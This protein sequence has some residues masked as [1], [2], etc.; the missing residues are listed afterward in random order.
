MHLLA[1]PRSRG[2]RTYGRGAALRLALAAAIATIAIPVGDA[3][4]YVEMP[5]YS[6]SPSNGAHL[7]LTP[8]Q[9]STPV[10][11]ES[12][13]DQYF[14]MIAGITLEVSPVSTLGQDGTLSDDFVFDYDYIHQSDTSPGHYITRFQNFRYNNP[15]IY[16]YQFSGF[17]YSHERTA[18]PI[19]Y[20]V[21]DPST[22]ESA[23][24]PSPA[25]PPAADLSMS[26]SN[27]ISYLKSL[28]KEK[29]H[30]RARRLS[31][32][33]RRTSGRSFTCTARFRAGHGRYAGRF[34][35][36]HIQGS[37]GT[38]YWTGTFRG[39]RSGGNRVKWSV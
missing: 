5:I 24:P 28:I 18:S 26:K 11:I 37:D 20:F 15:G 12:W 6:K 32:V 13:P 30:H 38:I 31:K 7:P 25:A 19:F 36:K 21:Y 3:F 27:A 39:H 4:A 1:D 33:C 23:P 17:T 16:Y 2:A 8:R 34:R 29:T 22:G 9:G 14:D 35:V 10:V